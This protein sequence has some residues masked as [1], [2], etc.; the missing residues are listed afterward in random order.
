[1]CD[2]AIFNVF[3]AYECY[4]ILR[5]MISVI[6]KWLHVVIAAPA[7]SCGIHAVQ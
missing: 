1:M 6:Y 2:I 4:F 7:E 5:E 3:L